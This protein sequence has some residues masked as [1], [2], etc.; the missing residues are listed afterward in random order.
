MPCSGR[1][2]CESPVGCHA[3][4]RSDTMRTRGR[5]SREYSIPTKQQKLL[6]EE[7]RTNDNTP[8]HDQAIKMRKLADVGKLDE[9]TIQSIMQETKPNQV[10]QFKM[11]RERLSKYFPPD[12]SMQKIEETII[13]A[14]EALRQRERSRSGDVS[15]TFSTILLKCIYTKHFILH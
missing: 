13:K 7:M 6:L 9:K 12:T 1:M 11:P 8:S 10:E 3:N 4:G 2:R 15:I 14:L 5:M